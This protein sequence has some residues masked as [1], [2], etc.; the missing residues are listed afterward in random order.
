[1]S[2]LLERGVL[3]GGDGTLHANGE[4]Q[5]PR[6]G[7]GRDVNYRLTGDG[8]QFLNDFGVGLPDGPVVIRYCVD[9]S[10]QRH[11]LSGAAGKALLG[12]LGELDWIRRGRNS[13]AVAVTVA[14]RTGLHETFGIS[15]A[16]VGPTAAT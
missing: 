8:Y 6:A 15:D 2:A 14:G 11:H 3:T 4:R 16:D 10:E 1:M 5:D 12:R 7:Y 9:W 13:R